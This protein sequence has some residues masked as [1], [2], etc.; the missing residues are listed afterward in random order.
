M[1]QCYRINDANFKSATAPSPKVQGPLTNN[2]NL[3]VSKF[4]AFKIS[5]DIYNALPVE[6]YIRSFSYNGQNVGSI[7]LS[8][9]IT[10]LRL[11]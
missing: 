1:L 9:S 5:T 7:A 11:Y 6:R 4:I 3:A 10:S 8:V 2:A